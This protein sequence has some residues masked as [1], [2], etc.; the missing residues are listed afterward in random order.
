MSLN[1]RI[2]ALHAGGRRSVDEVA[3]EVG[4]TPAEVHAR[5]LDP[6][7]PEAESEPGYTNASP[8]GVP[9]GFI[10]DGYAAG[11]VPGG[12]TLIGGAIARWDHRALFNVTARLDVTA[13]VIA[14]GFPQ[15]YPYGLARI[16][17]F[18]PLSWAPRAPYGSG[19]PGNTCPVQLH[20]YNADQTVLKQHDRTALVSLYA[21]GALRL[22]EH[23][24]D[25]SKLVAGDKITLASRRDSVIAF[26]GE[27][28]FAP[29]PLATEF[30]P[31]APQI[32]AGAT[33]SSRQVRYLHVIGDRIYAGY[34]D[35][36]AN[37]GP[38][39]VYSV[40][41]A[42]PTAAWTDHLT[43]DTEETGVF[44][45][46]ADG[47]ILVPHIDPRGVGGGYAERQANGVWVDRPQRIGA[48]NVEHVFDMVEFGGALWACGS[49]NDAARV[50]K[51][52][53]GGATWTADLVGQAGALSRYYGF[54]IYGDELLVISNSGGGF[55]RWTAAT[56]AWADAPYADGFQTPGATDPIY[57]PLSFGSGFEW[58]G[59][60]VTRSALDARS[61][62]PDDHN[63]IFFLHELYGDYI[64]QEAE[65]VALGDDGAI[66]LLIREGIFRCPAPVMQH[67]SEGEG[68][69]FYEW[70]ETSFPL[71]QVA[72][73]PHIEGV[74]QQWN[75]ALAILPGSQ[76][77]VVGTQ[78]GQLKLVDL[79]A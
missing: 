10:S 6:A 41:L 46:T 62:G 5:L 71:T 35:Y 42:D 11:W 37:T 4:V 55:K 49:G 39:R 9:V 25:T 43:A 77:A 73:V 69:D 20:H 54:T 19:Y 51:S 44:C 50:W 3:T 17:A 67:F 29:V 59:G 45:A 60:W 32:A 66:Y 16:L 70:V 57:W 53:D 31:A 14:D 75:T 23:G 18:A 22:A 65:D 33:V 47:R 7:L 8:G 40:P 48:V 64:E 72:T 13:G 58:G 28:T 26:P 63:G 38:I 79:D 56:G 27:A 34:G 24:L 21:D 61:L 76:R 12:W 2:R 30:A 52:T 74:S 78:G 68:E 1:A 15:G 36:N